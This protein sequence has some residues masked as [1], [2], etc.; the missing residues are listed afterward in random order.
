MPGSPGKSLR[1]LEEREILGRECASLAGQELWASFGRQAASIWDLLDASSPGGA[2]PT[3]TQDLLCVKSVQCRPQVSTWEAKSPELG[4][5]LSDSYRE[6]L[7]R[8]H[9]RF[10][11]TAVPSTWL[12]YTGV[13]PI[14]FKGSTN[15]WLKLHFKKYFKTIN[16]YTQVC[17][18]PNVNNHRPHELQVKLFTPTSEKRFPCQ[19]RQYIGIYV[20]MSLIRKAVV[21]KTP[22]NN[23]DP[24]KSPHVVK[25]YKQV[26]PTTV[27]HAYNVQSD[28][29]QSCGSPLRVCSPEERRVNCTVRI[30]HTPCHTV[31]KQGW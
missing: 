15:V 13:H 26:A 30:N 18:I 9:C 7:P 1:E 16:G 23:S 20:D 31:V 2:S 12:Q 25:L 28:A 17:A 24:C 8:W 27:A 6:A 3:A 29:R 19:N 14:C 5:H 4:R 10:H 22:W 21:L 11:E